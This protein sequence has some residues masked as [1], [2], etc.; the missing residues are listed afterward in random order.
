MENAFV[1]QIFTMSRP[2]KTLPMFL[3]SPPKQRKITNSPQAPLFSLSVAPA[4]KKKKK[5]KKGGWEAGMPLWALAW[6]FSLKWLLLFN[7]YTCA[8]L[9]LVE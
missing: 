7:E 5:K 3:P 6:D 2:D 9:L 8:E 4:K 1:S